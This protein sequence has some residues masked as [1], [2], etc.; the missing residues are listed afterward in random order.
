MVVFEMV[1]TVWFRFYPLITN[2]NTIIS[3]THVNRWRCCSEL[4]VRIEVWPCRVFLCFCRGVADWCIACLSVHRRVIQLWWKCR[5]RDL[6]YQSELRF[7]DNDR[8]EVPEAACL[9]CARLHVE[10]VIQSVQLS[11]GCWLQ[12]PAPLRRSLIHFTVSRRSNNESKMRNRDNF[13]NEKDDRKKKT[14]ALD[15][16]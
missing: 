3:S 11:T 4:C 8:P 10:T 6:I 1:M 2:H 14:R 9:H 13:K 5:K 7:V 12:A 15:A 16:Q